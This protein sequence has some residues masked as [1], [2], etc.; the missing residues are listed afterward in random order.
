M[1]LFSRE[2]VLDNSLPTAKLLGTLGLFNFEKEG[3]QGQKDKASSAVLAGDI[4]SYCSEP[5]ENPTR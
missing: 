2:S 5:C 4:S 1:T 3:N